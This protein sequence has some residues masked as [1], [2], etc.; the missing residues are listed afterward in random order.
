M[1]ETVVVEASKPKN[2]SPEMALFKA[3]MTGDEEGFRAALSGG[4]ID[5]NALHPESKITALHFAAFH[6][7]AGFAEEL[8]K[9]PII[10]CNIGS[11]HKLTPLHY[12]AE[13][14]HADVVR[15]LLN[16]SRVEVNAQDG[17]K[18]T[19]LHRA[20]L[21]GKKEVVEVLLADPRVNANA[22][23]EGK[24]TALELAR[25]SRFEDVAAILKPVT[26]ARAEALE[27]PSSSP[28]VGGVSSSRPTSV[29]AKH[30]RF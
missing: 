20:A 26:K 2:V 30:V 27:V 25:D 22:E 11:E 10:E 1:R 3:I 21:K 17:G 8:L 23:N 18:N 9:S 13:S 7:R 16:D 24:K 14:N 4:K 28:E 6:G 15:I 29:Q 12:A 5:V 19:P